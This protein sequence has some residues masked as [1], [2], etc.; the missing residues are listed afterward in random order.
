MIGACEA[1]TGRKPE[2]LGKPYGPMARAVLRLLGTT[3]DVTAM[4]GDQLDTDM[5]MAREAG[6]M[7][8]LVESDETRRQRS[9]GSFTGDEPP[10]VARN[11]V[12]LAGW[13]A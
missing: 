13:L 6:L 9:E 4:V 2:I 11:L 10:L 3:A 8:V 1:V 5:R 12:E 7:G